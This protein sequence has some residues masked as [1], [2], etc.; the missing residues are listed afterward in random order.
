MKKF[1]KRIFSI[2]FMFLLVSIL[3]CDKASALTNASTVASYNFSGTASAFGGN[4]QSMDFYYVA[5][6]ANYLKVDV[7]TSG[8][9]T[10]DL[11]YVAYDTYPS[12]RKIIAEKKSITAKGNSY[13]FYFIPQNGSCPGS[14]SQ[15]ITVP[16][17]NSY[18]MTSANNVA[19]NFLLWYGIEVHNGSVLGGTLS[20]SGTYIFM[21]Y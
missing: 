2:T 12:E 3:C 15:C 17:I 20:V 16:V 10:F 14:S 1:M 9:D 8:G 5:N 7:N 21:N 13:T 11:R 6:S 18:D 19:N 4:Y